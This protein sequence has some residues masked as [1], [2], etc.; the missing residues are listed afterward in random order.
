MVD[1]LLFHHAL[2]PTAGVEALAQRLRTAGHRVETPDLFDGRTFASID[3]GVDHATDVGFGTIVD[4]GVAAADGFS[5]SFVTI[6]LSLGALPAQK[7]AQTS[8]AVTGAVLCH[9]AAPV[10]AF[11]DAWP[12]GVDLQIHL[13]EDDPWAAEDVEVARGLVGR[14]RADL[15]LYPGTGHLVTDQSSPDWDPVI[16]GQIL[17]RIERFLA[18]LD[19][20]PV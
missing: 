11:G 9:A 13:V 8:P 3:D 1:V 5:E 17:D 15:H 10:D 12:D 7:L 20:P 2:G 14:A 19:R 18:G 4:R 6:G 16:A